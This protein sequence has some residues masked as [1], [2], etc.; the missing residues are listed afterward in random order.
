MNVDNQM[1]NKTKQFFSRM[2]QKLE[3]K[4]TV[5]MFQLQST[6]L[7]GQAWI[8]ISLFKSSE[9]NLHPIF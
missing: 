5:V 4:D 8:N 1:T 3:Q 2:K 7:S 6:T 9:E